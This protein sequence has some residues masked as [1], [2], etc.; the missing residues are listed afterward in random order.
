MLLSKLTRNN[1]RTKEG[2]KTRST[3]IKVLRKKMEECQFTNE[4]MAEQL[5]IDPSTFYRKLKADGTTFTVGQMHKI[6]EVLGLEP[7]EATAIFLW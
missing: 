4:K 1:A 3:N 2:M 7:E 5:C 6:V